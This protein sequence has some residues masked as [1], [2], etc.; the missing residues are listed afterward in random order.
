[1]TSEISEK[2][3]QIDGQRGEDGKPGKGG[4]GGLS[5]FNG[6]DDGWDNGEHV[7]GKLVYRLVK[8]TWIPD[9]YIII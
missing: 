1:M 4:L 6:V 7:R 3:V 2:I 5:G 8:R 9:K